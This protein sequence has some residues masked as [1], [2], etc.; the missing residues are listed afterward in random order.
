M[1]LKDC[2]LDID[3]VVMRP[4]M[5]NSPDPDWIQAHD[6]KIIPENVYRFYCLADYF[7]LDKVPKFLNDQNRLL[8]SFLHYLLLGILH[9]FEEAYELVVT[10]RDV[11]G[12]G[13]SPAKRIKGETWDP[14]ADKRQSRSLRYLIVTLTSTLDQFAEVVSIF[15]HGDIPDLTVG[16]S[17]F[18]VLRDFARSPFIPAAT[19]VTPKEHRFEELHAVLVEELEVKGTEVQ[20]FELLNLYRNKLAHLGT[21]MFPIS[22][23][24]DDK[25]QFYSFLPNRWPIFHESSISL[26]HES[27]KSDD[28]GKYAKENLIHQDVVEYS[29]RLLDKVYILIDR[30]FTV[31]CTTYKEFRDFDLNESALKSLQDKITQYSFK[32]FGS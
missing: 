10:I 13:Y 21:P 12:K 1:K 26:P 7:S 8:F 23:L 17:S 18:T 25:G 2:I 9:S 28:P 29:E 6:D 32:H 22:V 5:I 4:P 11:Q 27:R 15:F 14:D 30:C 19:I 20:W 3:R 31:L 24:H 16:R